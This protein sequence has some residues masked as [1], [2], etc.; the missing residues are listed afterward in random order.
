[1]KSF[2]SLAILFVALSLSVLCSEEAKS[3]NL[4]KETIATSYTMAKAHVDQYYLQHENDFK[5]VTLVNVLPPRKQLRGEVT[6][7]VEVPSVTDYYDG[8]TKFETTTVKCTQWT[9]QKEVCQKQRACGWCASSLSCIS[10][11]NLGPLAPCLR[12]RFEFS[13][14]KDN[15][16]PL[17]T[18]NVNVSRKQVGLA[19]LTTFTPK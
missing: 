7:V 15:W 16:N 17:E 18:D 4:M 2:K 14:P 10:G 1:M 6:T 9:H 11:N 13:A 5:G 19:Q 8:T 3:M 12:G